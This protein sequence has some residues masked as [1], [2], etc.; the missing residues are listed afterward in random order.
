MENTAPPPESPPTTEG[1]LMRLPNAPSLDTLET[2]NAVASGLTPPETQQASETPPLTPD[3]PLPPE[4]TAQPVEQPTQEIDKRTDEEHDSKDGHGT[5][6]GENLDGN[7]NMTK[8]LEQTADTMTSDAAAVIAKEVPDAPPEPV[9]T[10]PTPDATTQEL[11]GSELSAA[12][13]AAEGETTSVEKGISLEDTIRLLD[14][15]QAEVEEAKKTAET[16]HQ[17][18][19]V[20]F[21]ERVKKIVDAKTTI[22]ALLEEKIAA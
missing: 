16:A 8:P 1:P 10:T 15:K 13:K 18:N 2:N 11:P 19:M 12:D 20:S 3:V 9:S 17:S 5:H 6:A 14:T 7:W 21:D 22:Q 4:I